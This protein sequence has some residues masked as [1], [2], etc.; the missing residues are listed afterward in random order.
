MFTVAPFDVV[1]DIG[2]VGR[3]VAGAGEVFSRGRGMGIGGRLACGFTSRR[4]NGGEQWTTPSDRMMNPA[5]CYCF[6]LL[7]GYPST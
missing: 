6:T 7:R 5:D 3:Q 4:R 1:E 2:D